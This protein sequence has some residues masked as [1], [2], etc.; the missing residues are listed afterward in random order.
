MEKTVPI[1]MPIA[2][3]FHA[4]ARQSPPLPPVLFPAFRGL[5]FTKRCRL[6]LLTKSALVIRVQMQGSCGVSANEYNSA[7]HVTWSSNKLWRS[8]S[9]FNL[10]LRSTS[11]VPTSPHTHRLTQCPHTSPSPTQTHPPSSLSH[12][13]SPISYPSSS[14]SHPLYLISHPTSHITYLTHLLCRIKRT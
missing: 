11:H 6:S 5:Q 13:P 10:C 12:P 3:S 8:N 1:P 14:I 7:H 9:I 2:H 4:H